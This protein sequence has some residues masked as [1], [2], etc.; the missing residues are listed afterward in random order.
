M[1]VRVSPVDGVPRSNFELDT[2]Y[3]MQMAMRGRM[4]A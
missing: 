3:S 1:T 2:P 4:K